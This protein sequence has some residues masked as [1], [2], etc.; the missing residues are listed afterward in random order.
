MNH[1]IRILF[2]A[3][4]S[5]LC[6]GSAH[7][8]DVAPAKLTPVA[9]AP[10]LRLA[11][12][13]TYGYTNYGALIQF[14]L[15]PGVYRPEYSDKNGIYY[16]GPRNA[17]EMVLTYDNKFEKG[18]VERRPPLEGGVFLDKAGTALIYYYVQAAKAAPT[19]STEP[20]GGVITNAVNDYLASRD[21]KITFARKMRASAELAGMLE[22]EP[23]AAEAAR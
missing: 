19:S 13:F 1:W 7:G 22:P 14:A 18:H 10:A 8:K 15:N 4:A 9:E 20:G 5:A 11:Q 2:L 16:R 3:V 12:P 23:A 17:V 6:S 21:G